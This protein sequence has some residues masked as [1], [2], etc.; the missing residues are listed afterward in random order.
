MDQSRSEACVITLRLG[1]NPDHLNHGTRFAR[2][3]SKTYQADAFLP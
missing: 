3:D 2:S 1:F